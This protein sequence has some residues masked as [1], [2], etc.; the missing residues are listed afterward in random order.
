[1]RKIFV[2]AAVACGVAGFGIPAHAQLLGTSVTGTLEFGGGPPN[3]Y[4]PTILPTDYVPAG[5]DNSAGNANSPTVTIGS[6]GGLVEFGF[7]DIEDLV[8][9]DFT[10]N[11]LTLTD[12]VGEAGNAGWE[13]TFT[14][15][16]FS[17]LSLSTASDTFGLASATLS[18]DTITVDWGGTDTGNTYSATFDFTSSVPEPASMVLLATGLV[19]LGALRRRRAE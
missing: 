11:M 3:Y 2:A 8:T 16:A 13:Q 19:G 1:M 15:T 17:G 14:D 9:A 10:D 18:D 12:H 4:D 6:Y 7:Q 5:Y